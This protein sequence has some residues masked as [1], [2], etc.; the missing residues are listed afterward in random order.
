MRFC[1]LILIAKTIKAT[2]VETKSEAR[3]FI[4]PAVIKIYFFDDQKSGETKS[5]FDLIKN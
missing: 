1:H 3:M 4:F 5:G 2:R